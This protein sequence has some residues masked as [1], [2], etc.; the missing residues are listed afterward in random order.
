MQ[1]RIKPNEQ[2]KFQIGTQCCNCGATE[3][4]EY[5][6]I[7]PLAIGGKD[8][9]SN[10]CCLCFL[11]H[12]LI[13][14]NGK[15]R[16]GKSRSELIKAGIAKSEKT[17]GRKKG[18]LDKMTNELKEDIETYLKD[19]NVTQNDLM[20]THKISRNTLKKYIKIIEINQKIANG[21]WVI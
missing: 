12:E 4:L 10:M 17:Q 9:V 15:Q 7:V 6:H 21:D 1:N 8:T 16:I 11:C 19:K 14:N 18:T 20:N 13:H 3:A 2:L 5:H